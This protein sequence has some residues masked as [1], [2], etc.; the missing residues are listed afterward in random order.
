[1]MTSAK[2]ESV[3][4]C[5]SWRRMGSK[6]VV[7]RFCFVAPRACANRASW[8]RHKPVASINETTAASHTG[9]GSASRGRA[10]LA[11]IT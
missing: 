7:R 2:Y 4:T 10:T 6:R 1:M 3:R 9:H 8:L 11:V 5:S